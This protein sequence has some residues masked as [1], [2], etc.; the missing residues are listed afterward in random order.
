MSS[1]KEKDRECSCDYKLHLIDSSN[2]DFLRGL[3]KEKR[4]EIWIAN[5]LVSYLEY[6]DSE[7]RWFFF[8][9]SVEFEEQE[10]GNFSIYINDIGE[11][12]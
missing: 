4:Y 2:V 9:K 1:S 8:T 6:I 12:K 7:N 11:E 5:K 10:D 3:N